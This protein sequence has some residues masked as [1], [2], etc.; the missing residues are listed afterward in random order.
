MTRRYIL[1]LITCL[2]AA[3]QNLHA[4][5]GT[6][7]IYA[8]SHDAQETVVMDGRVYVLSDGS[9]YSYDPEDTSVETYDKEGILSDFGIYAIRYSADTRE[10]VIVYTNGNI[11]LLSADGSVYNLPDLKTKTLSDKTINDVNIDGTSLYICTASG[12]VAVNLKARAFADFYSLGQAVRSVTPVDG[13]L[14]AALPDGIYKGLKTDNLLDPANWKRVM[15]AGFLRMRTVN[16]HI[17]GISPYLYEINLEQVKLKELI[18]GRVNDIAE[19]DNRLMAYM[20]T[21]VSAVSDDG[22]VS[23]INGSEGI[24]GICHGNGTYWAACGEKGL[25]GIDLKDNAVV[26]KVSSVIP[27]SPYR[28]Y[29]YTLNM[30]DNGRLLVGGGTFNYPEENRT[31]TVLVYENNTW[32]RFDEDLIL[33]QVHTN[34]YL[35]VTKVVQDPEDSEHH[36]VSTARSGLYEFRNRKMVNHYTY[37]NSPLAT[38]RPS[39]SHAYWYVRTTGLAYDKNQNLWML[40]TEVDTLIHILR[41][42]GTWRNLYFSELDGNPT[43]DHIYF[44]RRGWAWINSRRM[45]GSY[46]AGFFVLDP[47]TNQ[48]ISHGPFTN[49]DGIVYD[50]VLFFCM[51]EDLDGT[52]WFGCSQGLFYNTNP[53]EVFNTDFVLSQV[54]VPRNDGT[55]LADYL[56]NQTTVTCIAID[57]GNR[58]WVGTSGAGVFLLSPDGLETIAQFTAENSPLISNDIYD[59]AINGSTGEVFIG[60]DAGLVSYMGDAT[61]PAAEMTESNVKVYPNPVR[62]GYNGDIKVTGLAYETQVKIVNAAGHLVNEGTSVGGTYVWSGRLASGKRCASGIYYVLAADSEGKNGVAAK[63]L[64]VSE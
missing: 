9:L 12:I 2:F 31:G 1:I 56:L 46:K 11:D 7:R 60:T 35:N 52:M 5:N 42:D 41:K 29:S 49:Q 57:G 58:K 24:N 4:D 23:P 16:G 37:T 21:G 38:I 34:E 3:M 13:G 30:T 6:W 22:T 20:D 39:S 62:P 61:D 53:S 36:W 47:E 40:T 54:K 8:A 33:S 48:R 25:M 51:T 27:N 32:D 18:K 10:V 59:I 15:N 44:D 28:N 55:N 45:V 14:L 64:V 19:M 50:P 17:Y 26:E 63:L 43:I